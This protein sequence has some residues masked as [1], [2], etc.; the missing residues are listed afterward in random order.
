V[1]GGKYGSVDPET[2]RSYTEREYDL[3]VFLGKPVQPS[4]MEILRRSRLVK[5]RL[6]RPFVRNLKPA[7]QGRVKG[8]LQTSAARQIASLAAAWAAV[9]AI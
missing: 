9:I 6:R 1:I 5:P 3:A 4:C 2:E 7:A 8:D